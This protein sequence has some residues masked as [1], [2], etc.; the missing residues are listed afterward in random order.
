M[1][2]KTIGLRLK[3]S[4]TAYNQN[5]SIPGFVRPWLYYPC[6]ST[7]F[8]RRPRPINAAPTTSAANAPSTI[9]VPLLPV[10]GSVC[11]LVVGLV[12]PLAEL[13]T[14]ELGP[15]EPAG[16]YV[17][18]VLV[19]PNSVDGDTAM[20]VVLVLVLVL[21]WSNSN[22]VVVDVDVDVLVEV[23]VL[24][25]DEVL[26]DD[27]VLDSLTVVV[28]VVEVGV[29][30]DV[31]VEL[32]VEVDVEL[33]VLVDVAVEEDVDVELDVDDEVELE[34]LELDEELEVGM[35][36]VDVVVVELLPQPVTL[37]F[38]SLEMV[39]ATNW[40]FKLFPSPKLRW[41][42]IERKCPETLELLPKLTATSLAPVAP[43]ART[44]TGTSHCGPKLESLL[45]ENVCSIWMTTP[46][47]VVT[48]AC[49]PM[50]RSQKVYVPAASVVVDPSFHTASP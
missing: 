16:P 2:R 44:Y 41:P 42:S 32:D 19:E 45:I 38:L 26:V 25:G 27:D 30:V 36:V 8:R 24:V 13:G 35:F 3:M 11:S 1:A 9:P 14:V 22:V 40:P 4:H 46:G 23:D 6:R 48:V 10:N 29:L 21:V 18:D 47:T 15:V 37:L 34:E 7:R 28:D 39:L 49:F 31:D 43:S 20:L 17:V 12:D 33:E 5:V 50:L